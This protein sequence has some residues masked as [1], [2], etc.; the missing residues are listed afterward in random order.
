MGLSLHFSYFN[1]ADSDV[2]NTLSAPSSVFMNGED[3]G[4]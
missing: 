3:R 1:T 4:F 2:H